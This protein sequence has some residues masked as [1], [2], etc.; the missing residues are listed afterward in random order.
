MNVTHRR[1]DAS[2]DLTVVEE[3]LFLATGHTQYFL[4]FILQLFVYNPP[5]SR[6]DVKLLTRI[7]NKQ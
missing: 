4:H 5:S 6:K 2:W 7:R 3:V 1:L